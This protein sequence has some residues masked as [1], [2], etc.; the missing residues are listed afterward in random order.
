[1][2]RLG[3]FTNAKGNVVSLAAHLMGKKGGANAGG[4]GCLGVPL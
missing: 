3:V 2:A 4:W 1:M